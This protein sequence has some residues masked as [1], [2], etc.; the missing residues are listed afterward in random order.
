[1]KKHYILCLLVVGS[2][3]DAM[4]DF[5]PLNSPFEQ[6]RPNPQLMIAIMK[7]NL[8]EVTR[9]LKEGIDPNMRNFVNCT[10]LSL[11]R[12]MKNP[13]FTRL[14]L[15]YGADPNAVCMTRSNENWK[16]LDGVIAFGTEEHI[17]LLLK[18]GANPFEI[19][20][21]TFVFEKEKANIEFVQAERMKRTTTLLLCLKQKE[22][23]NLPN[24]PAEI[25]EM[26]K[27]AVREICTK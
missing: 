7:Q 2:L 15:E 25:R 20:K 5:D 22:W 27:R 21:K 10:P 6:Y 9:L 26:I 8:P 18:H 19:I 17:Q 13:V 24:L 11:T 3:I 12:D 23:D 14:L 1:M 16:E 4:E